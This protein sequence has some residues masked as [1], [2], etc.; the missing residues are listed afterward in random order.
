MSDTQHEQQP[1]EVAR[2]ARD[3][4]AIVEL[5]LQIP[6]QAIHK[7]NATIDGTGL[8]GGLAMVSLAS[9]ASPEA[10]ENIYEAR[11]AHGRSSDHVADEDD[12]WESPLQSLLFWS[13]QWRIEHN[14]ESDRRPTVGSEAAFIRQCLDWAWDHELQ[15][16]DFARDIN[17]ARVR[18]EEVLYAGNR[19]ERTRVHCIDPVC[20]RKPRLIKVYRQTAAE[21]HYKCPSCKELYSAQRFIRAKADLLASQGADR[22]V[23][24]Q[25]AMGAIDRPERTFR[26]WLR[27]WYVRSYRDPL[28]GTVMVWWPDVRETDMNTQKR[29]AAA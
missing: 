1:S 25:D 27:F 21:D 11:E 19:V 20:E 3:L 9:V 16:E 4:T 2:V 13:E 22:H 8:P 14:R 18:L 29:N 5:A 24:M 17:Q 12:T 23:P 7:A 15:F 10:W 26:K 28:T 6:A